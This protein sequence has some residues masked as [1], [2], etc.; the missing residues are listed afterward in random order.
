MGTELRT[1]EGQGGLEGARGAVGEQ[2]KHY[3]TAQTGE[4]EA[5]HSK[6]NTGHRPASIPATHIAPIPHP[7]SPL[8]HNDSTLLQP[9]GLLHSHQPQPS[10]FARSLGMLTQQCKEQQQFWAV[11]P[12]V[13]LSPQPQA[14]PQLP[15]LCHG[16]FF[17]EQIVCMQ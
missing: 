5:Q 7:G 17:T 2:W 3:S 12:S 16:C 4:Q 11:H 10:A 14:H 13:R 9:N 1:W 8:C 6:H 15:F